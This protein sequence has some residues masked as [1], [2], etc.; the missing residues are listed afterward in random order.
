VGGYVYRGAAMPELDGWY[1]FGDNCSG[2]IRAYNTSG[3]EPPM[4]LIDGGSSMFSMAELPNGEIVVLAS[5]NRI[6]QL[7]RG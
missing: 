7:V 1:I 6:Y 4:I 5:D 2:R 3:S